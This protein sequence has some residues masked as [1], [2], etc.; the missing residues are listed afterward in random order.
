VSEPPARD[1][2]L[3]QTLVEFVAWVCLPENRPAVSSILMSTPKVD[4]M[5]EEMAG[6]FEHV[7]SVLY[8]GDEYYDFRYAAAGEPESVYVGRHPVYV[9]RPDSPEGQEPVAESNPR[10]MTH[11]H[12][13]AQA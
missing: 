13:E 2:R 8:D 1:D 11:D 4:S 7:G 12:R 6:L 9:V 3:F 10:V 5:A